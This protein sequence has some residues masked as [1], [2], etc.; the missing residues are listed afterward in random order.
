VYKRQILSYKY[1]ESVSGKSFVAPI[2]NRADNF[3][4]SQMQYH[5]V[6]VPKLV[7]TSREKSHIML[8]HLAHYAVMFTLALVQLLERRLSGLFDVIRGRRRVI[9]D[10]HRVSA[11][12]RNMADK[13]DT[14]KPH[15][16]IHKQAE[17]HE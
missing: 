7:Q 8:I 13:T 6:A 12:L 11:Y 14:H 5:S 17:E 16:M 2:R 10:T 1:W 9:R 3:V 15:D 4:V